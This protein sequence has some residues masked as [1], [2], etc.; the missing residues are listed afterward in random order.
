MS[1]IEKS[2]YRVPDKIQITKKASQ[3]K[4]IYINK[5]NNIFG[6]MN[7]NKSLKRLLVTEWLKRALIYL[8]SHL[9]KQ[10]YLENKS[11]SYSE[12]SVRGINR[13]LL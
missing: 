5:W 2:N 13:Y 11:T 6:N 4:N 7:I 3:N 12:T 9:K 1:G 10:H 8:D